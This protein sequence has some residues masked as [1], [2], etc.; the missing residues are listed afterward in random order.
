MNQSI[1]VF[2]SYV[3]DLMGRSPHLPQPGETVKGSLFQMGAGGKGFNQAVAACKAGARVDLITKLGRDAFAALAEETMRSLGMDTSRLL[4]TTQTGTGAALILVDET[5]GQN[6]IVVIPGAC[7]TI[8]LEE[9][10]KC[11]PAIRAGGWLLTQLE[12]NLDAMEHAVHLAYESG[13]RVVLN[14]APAQPVS[15]RLLSMVEIITPNE[16]EAEILTGI[17]VDSEDSARKA[18]DVFFAK[19]V[20]QVVITLGGRGAFVSTGK[21]HRLLPPFP[22]RAVDTT[23]AG[24]AFNGGLVAALAEGLDLWQ[25]ARFAGALAALS[26]TRLGTSCAMPA[27]AEVESLLDAHPDIR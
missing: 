22:V 27:R 24:D 3:A 6:E 21:A 20:K 18:A 2:G 23:G 8:S 16:V 12:T 25:A 14:P 19:G 9:V 1:T 13:V 26:V 17:K 4:Y 10:E 11:A 15:D 5:T 7:E